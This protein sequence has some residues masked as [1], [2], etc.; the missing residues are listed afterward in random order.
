MNFDLNKYMDMAMEYLPTVLLAIF[1]LIIG[2]WVVKRLCRLAENGMEKRNMELSLRSFLSSILSILLKTMLILSV[3]SMFG[4]E[5]TSFVAI[6]SALMI[7][8]G[9]ALNGT[10]GHFAS[11]VMLMI[12]KPFKV[13]DLVQIGGSKTLG[14]VKELSAFN[15][16]LE[17]WDKKRVIISNSNVTGND[18]VNISG[19]GELGVDINF[20]IGYDDDIDEARRI[21]LAVGKSN[22]KILS[23]PV[24]T[25]MVAE[26]A[27]SS[28][29]L[30][31]RPFCKP[32]DYWDVMFFMQEHVKK[33]FDKNGIGIPFPQMDVHMKQS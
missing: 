24:Q 1:T 32:A 25:V 16:I 15:T 28:V 5:T 27:D 19:Q 23:T 11:G 18:I 21:I 8:V 30:K 12:F 26:L 3:V 14:R 10:I 2:L 22:P 20:G 13:G 9:M 29:N 7:G 33:E 4:V 31:T 6:I 17:T